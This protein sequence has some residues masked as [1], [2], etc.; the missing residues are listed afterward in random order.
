MKKNNRVICINANRL[1]E[2]SVNPKLIKGR[3]YI[4]YASRSCPCGIIEFDVGLLTESFVGRHICSVCNHSQK[5]DGIHWC[6][7]TRFA[8]VKEQ[9]KVVHMDIAIEE[10][11]LN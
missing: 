9:Y 6:L 1:R 8:I 2:I 10:P 4:I 7:S 5:S 3:E 11:T